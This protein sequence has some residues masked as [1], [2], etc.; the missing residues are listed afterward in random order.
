MPTIN[1][2][3]CPC[4]TKTNTETQPAI[5]MPFVAHRALGWA[6]QKIDTSWGLRDIPSG[7][8]LSLCNSVI[9]HTCGFLFCDIRFNDDEMSSLYAGYRGTEYSALREIYEPGYSARNTQLN[10]GYDYIEEVE[11]FLNPFVSQDTRIL[12]WGG[13]TGK[14]TPFRNKN[15]V[16]VL[17]ISGKD[18]LDGITVVTPEEIGTECF[19]LIICSNVL[20]HVPHPSSLIKD[21]MQH[22]SEDSVLYIEVP[23]EKTMRDTCSHADR[24]ASK[25]HWHE[26]INFYSIDAMS[27]MLASLD[28]EIKSSRFIEV[29]GFA[30]AG[31]VLQFIVRKTLL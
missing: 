23:Y 18:A 9:C 27:R 26:H 19:D 21:M 16:T 24:L 28:L 8:A 25:R 6:P 12:D 3:H 14:N 11:L 13:D 17:E 2:Q 1:T 7:N 10:A 22:M 29:E 31:C 20:E 5:L 4:C 30:A 15:P